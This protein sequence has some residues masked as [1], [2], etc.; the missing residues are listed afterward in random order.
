M[1][2]VIKAIEHKEKAIFGQMWHPEKENPISKPQILLIQEF[3]NENISKI[4]NIAKSASE[5][6]IE[7]YNND[8]RVNY[9]EDESPLTKADIKANKII[10]NKLNIIS[11]YPIITE[12]NLL[13]MRSE[14]LEQILVSRPS[15]W[16]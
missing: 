16:H 1:K 2:G 3:F 8:F 11:N 13:N 14:K 10:I 15:R 5:K 4:I 12:E 9:K 6:I 7:I